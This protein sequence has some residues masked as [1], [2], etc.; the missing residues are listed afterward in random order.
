ME[1]SGSGF[2][3]IITDPGG[4]KTNG[5][6]FGTLLLTYVSCH[7]YLHKVP[8]FFMSKSKGGSI[9]LAFLRLA[10]KK[11]TQQKKKT[12]ALRLAYIR[13]ITNL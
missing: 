11:E 13:A 12:W 4:L 7:Y 2:E 10:K 8:I 1:G 6:V 9:T 5:S 3:Q